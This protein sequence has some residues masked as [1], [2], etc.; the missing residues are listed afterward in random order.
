MAGPTLLNDIELPRRCFDPADL[1][2]R[3][4]VDANR[5]RQV[6]FLHGAPVNAFEIL[7]QY[8]GVTRAASR[9]HVD[10]I[11]FRFWILLGPD[12]VGAVATGAIGGHQQTAF[13]QRL[14]VN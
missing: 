1:V 2:R 9:W 3:M 4:A 14:A 13:L 10:A 6:T 12:V 5:R 8:P 11:D 7:V